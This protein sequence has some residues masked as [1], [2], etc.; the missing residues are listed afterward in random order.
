MSEAISAHGTLV[1]RNG[2][3]IGELKDITPPALERKTFDTSNQNDED[4]SYIVGIRRR[5]ELTF[6]V[7]FLPS[8]DATHGAQTGLIQ[9]WADGS[10]DLYQVTFPD[11]SAWL[12]SGFLTNIAP[13]A[14]TDGELSATITIRPT[15][16]MLFQ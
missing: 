4:D 14:P 13:K 7:N 8:G 9:A 16:G 1:A 10:K 2:V 3:T 12:F 6:T 11:D 15:N 5:G